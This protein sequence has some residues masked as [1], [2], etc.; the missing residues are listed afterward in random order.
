M[1]SNTYTKKSLIF[2]YFVFNDVII[3]LAVCAKIFSIRDKAQDF[4][5][6]P[7][8]VEFMMKMF[9]TFWATGVY[10]FRSRSSIFQ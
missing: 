7:I 6:K 2:R 4:F 5:H 9:T 3:L 10:S 8:A 1:I